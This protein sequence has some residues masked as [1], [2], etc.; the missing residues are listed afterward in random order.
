[1]DTPTMRSAPA[2][3]GPLRLTA[4]G[5]R[6]A[7]DP[8]MR[9]MWEAYIRRSHMTA[10]HR[11]TALTLASHADYTTGHIPPHVPVG[12]GDLAFETGLD[13]ARV[14]VALAAL[15]MRCLTAGPDGVPVRLTLPAAILDRLRALAVPGETCAP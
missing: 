2:P 7:G 13:P 11:H 5:E 4:L 12:V 3:A 14:R 6:A 10:A 1:M 9:A 8:P 15:E